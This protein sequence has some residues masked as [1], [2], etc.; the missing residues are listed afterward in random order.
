MVA[1]FFLYIYKRDILKIIFGDGPDVFIL[2]FRLFSCAH[3][4]KMASA[5]V[6]V[7]SLWTEVNRCGQN[8]DFTRALKA[9]TKSMTSSSVTFILT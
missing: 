6:S 3:L 4:A 1:L 9:L 7:A 5:G 2:Y 8:G